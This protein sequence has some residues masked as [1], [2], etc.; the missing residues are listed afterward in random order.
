MFGCYKC[1]DVNA[2]TGHT[3]VGAIQSLLKQ[4]AYSVSELNGKTKAWAGNRFLVPISWSLS[5]SAGRTCVMQRSV[6]GCCPLK[7]RAK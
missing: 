5:P 4:S 2:L 6:M 3:A 1:S 7:L